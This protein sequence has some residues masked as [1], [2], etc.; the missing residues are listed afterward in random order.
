M[1]PVETTYEAPELRVLGSVYELTQTDV[2]RQDSQG[3]W[4]VFNKTFGEPDFWSQIPI[5]TCS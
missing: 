2:I 3:R 5:T 4:C 1:M